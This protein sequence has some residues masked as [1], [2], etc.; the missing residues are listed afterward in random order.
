[1]EHR[2]GPTP[3]GCARVDIKEF[4]PYSKCRLNQKNGGAGLLMAWWNGDGAARVLAHD[5]HA[6]LL[7]RATGTMSLV[8]MAREDRDDEA[9]RIISAVIARLHAKRDVP[10]PDLIP[11]SRWFEPLDRAGHAHGGLL[12]RSAALARELLQAPEDIAVLHGDI[13]HGNVLDAGSRG[14]IAIDPKRLVGERG[15]DYANLFCNPDRQTATSPQRLARQAS[16]VA[17]AAGLNRTRLL[18]WIAAWAGLSAVWLLE[19]GETPELDLTIL[20]LALTELSRSETTV[21]S[22]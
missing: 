13:H 1:M 2:F 11:L 8:D 16:V 17:E 22:G 5:E 15:F 12:G 14:C 10:P 3:V 19:D 21:Y 18:K 20:K 4:P 6:L 9:S 7:E